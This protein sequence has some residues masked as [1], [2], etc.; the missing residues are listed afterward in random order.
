[1]SDTPTPIVPETPA[2]RVTSFVQNTASLELAVANDLGKRTFA[3]VQN[4]LTEF[5]KFIQKMEKLAS[6]GGDVKMQS[7]VYNMSFED[8][9]RVMGDAAADEIVQLANRGRA[10]LQFFGFKKKGVESKST[11]LV[12]GAKET[13]KSVAMVQERVRPPTFPGDVPLKSVDVI[14]LTPPP[15]APSID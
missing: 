10:F 13:S 3:D 14:P 15:A 2:P 8:F 4:G 9:R 1:M 11:M 12:S 7:D 5:D 6:N